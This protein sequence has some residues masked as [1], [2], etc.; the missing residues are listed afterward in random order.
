MGHVPVLHTPSVLAQRGAW[1]RKGGGY[2]PP[3]GLAAANSAS[4]REEANLLGGHSSGNTLTGH[5]RTFPGEGIV[6]RS[7]CCFGS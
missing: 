4:T 3:W 5:R 7:I 2:L 6:F 1:T